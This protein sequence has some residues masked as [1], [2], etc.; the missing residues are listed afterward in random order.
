MWNLPEDVSAPY[1]IMEKEEN[2]DD[3]DVVND[4][5]DPVF[6]SKASLAQSNSQ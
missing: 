6:Y 4:E 3:L 1:A 2:S 5:N